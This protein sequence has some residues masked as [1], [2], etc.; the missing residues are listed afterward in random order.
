[1]NRTTEQ[2]SDVTQATG[3]S[4]ALPISN[5]R[6]GLRRWGRSAAAMVLM[7]AIAP[8]FAQSSG[9]GRS[10]EE[11]RNTVINLLEALVQKGVMTREQAEAMVATA[12][13][14]A[15]ADAKA[16]AENEAAEAGA[17]RVTHV[18][19]IVQK[20]IRDQVRAELK[21]EVAREV[22][23]QAKAEQWGVPGALP[24]WIRDVKVYG[25]VRARA[26]AV[27]YADD[28]VPLIPNFQAIND[29]GGE[30]RAGL[31]AILNTTQDRNRLVGRA[32]LGML[33]QLGDSFAVDLRLASGNARSPVSTN[34][35]MGNYGG[36]WTVNVDKAAVI[37]NPVNAEHDRAFDLRFGRFSNPFVAP[38]EMIW[39]NDL[40][41]EG[42]SAKYS[43]DLFG[44]ESGRTEH[45][46][47]LALGAFPLQEVELSSD[48]KWLFGGQ[49]GMEFSFAG[50]SALRFAAAYYDYRNITGVLNPSPEDYTF[51]FTA[52]E[53]L[54]KGNTLFDIRNSADESQNLYALAGEYQLMN[55]NLTLDLGFDP[56]HVVV[57]ADYVKNLGWDNAAVNARTGRLGKERTD[58][59][60][61]GV[62]VGYPRTTDFGHWRAFALY[63]Y[64]ERDAT[65]DAFTDSDFQLGGTDAKGYQ[66]GFDLGLSRGTWL[67]L[68]YLTA[69]QI[70][71]GD[72]ALTFADL[73][74]GI[75]VW[76]LDLNGQF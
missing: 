20:Q 37:W 6:P 48:D 59:Y 62:S 44:S 75:D 35:T 46:V 18:P 4:M 58:G 50:S 17:V 13:E 30:A 25:D 49:L 57:S 34:Q 64:L 12:Q 23:A 63:R 61:L 41:F 72:P 55:A 3:D 53:F 5:P 1:M 38:N 2:V 71:D 10:L 52:P 69:D 7:A 60:E 21:D 67:R 51:D 32:R 56:M 40:T 73:P 15:G 65:L 24:A 54:Q 33:A 70:D 26:E 28:N 19:E 43:M 66:L 8:A 42:I 27:Q 39:D 22:V 9:A 14:K 45:G 68:R 31:N 74:L 47:F 11:V 36:R 29:A 76:Q 16:R